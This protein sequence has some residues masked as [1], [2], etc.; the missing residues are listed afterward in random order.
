MIA[1]ILTWLLGPRCDLCADRV[2]PRDLEAHL[3]IDHA[4]DVTP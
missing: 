1:R 3:Y 2:Y 4:G